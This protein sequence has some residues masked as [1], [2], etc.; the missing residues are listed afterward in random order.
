MKTKDECKQDGIDKLLKDG[1]ITIKHFGKS[2]FKCDI[3]VYQQNMMKKH[4]K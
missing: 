2:Y 1:K 4:M 3:N